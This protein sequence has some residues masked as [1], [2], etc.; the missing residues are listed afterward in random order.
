MRQWNSWQIVCAGIISIGL[1]AMPA[2]AAEP[3]PADPS[4][5]ELMQQI[6]ALQQKVQQLEAKQEQQQALNKAAVDA[7][8]RDLVSDATRRS[9]FLDNDM[10]FVGG[11]NAHKQQFFLGS[12]DGNFYF[13]P[14]LIAQFRNNTNFRENAKNGGDDT[15]N[16]FE[17]RRAKF[18]FDGN[19]FSKDLSYK[20]MWQDNAAGAPTLEWGYAQYVFAH[21]MLGGDLALR[22]GQFKD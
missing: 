12:E 10:R 19:V 15:E 5:Q 13:H 16:G 2:R 11:W 1:S 14:G 22:G 3:A 7:T 20:F 9:Q 6:K 8:V 4:A 17:V 21:D 18:Y